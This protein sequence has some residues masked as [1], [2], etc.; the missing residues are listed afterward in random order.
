MRKIINYSTEAILVFLSLMA[1]QILHIAILPFPSEISLFFKDLSAVGFL[2]KTT[3]FCLIFWVFYIFVLCERNPK[4]SLEI[5]KIIGAIII[6]CGIFCAKGITSL[7]NRIAFIVLGEAMLPFQWFAI[8]VLFC[9]CDNS[10]KEQRSVF[11]GLLILTSLWLPI[12]L[13]F[14][15]SILSKINSLQ[16]SHYETSSVVKTITR[17]SVFLNGVQYAIGESS[18]GTV[19]YFLYEDS[20]GCLERPGRQVSKQ[21]ARL[22][23]SC[24]VSVLAYLI[25]L[26][27]APNGCFVSASNK[28]QDSVKRDGLNISTQITEIY[29]INSTHSTR[30]TAYCKTDCDIRYDTKILCSITVDG[31]YPAVQSSQIGDL[32]S[33]ADNYMV[34]SNSRDE[35]GLFCNCM[36][37]IANSEDFHAFQID[38]LGE[39]AVNGGITALCEKIVEEKLFFAFPYDVQYLLHWD[40]KFVTPYL[41]DYERMDD[42]L[43]ERIIEQGIRPEYVQTESVRLLASRTGDGS[44]SQDEK[45]N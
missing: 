25:C 12:S 28:K 27:A 18:F 11:V 21:I 15:C 32:T 37:V 2:F 5:R 31:Y 3:L 30:E 6:Q 40:S 26:F 19:F 33:L 23:L 34:V 38:S 17:N 16:V 7:Q 4:E 41:N 1:L 35:I 42:S 24:L 8:L 20:K 44:L 9:L 43:A 10:L 45:P 39:Q 36:V 29:R 13:Y 14:D 22:L